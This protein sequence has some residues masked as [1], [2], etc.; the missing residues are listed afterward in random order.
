MKLSPF[1]NGFI[2]YE[3]TGKDQINLKRKDILA[4]YQLLWRNFIP[5]H[6]VVEA[7]VTVIANREEIQSFPGSPPEP[8]LDSDRRQGMTKEDF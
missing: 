2:Y 1:V 8:V 7:Q 5:P 6:N 3:D 4:I